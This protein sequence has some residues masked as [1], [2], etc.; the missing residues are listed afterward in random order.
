MQSYLD[1]I[2]DIPDLFFEKN[3]FLKDGT[4]VL[5]DLKKN[6]KR[7]FNIC[8]ENQSHQ[9]FD[10]IRT[11]D[12]YSQII[13]TNKCLDKK[14][15]IH[16]NNYLAFFC[17]KEALS[18]LTNKMIEDYYELLKDPSIKYKKTETS[19]YQMIEEKFPEPDSFKIERCKQWI[20]DNIGLL[21]IEGKYLKIFFKDSLNIYRQENLRYLIPNV[22]LNN[23]YNQEVEKKC[24][25]VPSGNLVLNDKKPFLLHRTRKNELPILMSLEDALTRRKFISLLSSLTLQRK[26]NIFISD[27]QIIACKNGDLPKEI[28]NGFFIKVL[29]GTLENPIVEEDVVQFNPKLKKA[30]EYKNYLQGVEDENYPYGTIICSKEELLQIVD[31]IYFSGQLVNNLFLP[32]EKIISSS[33]KLSYF[34]RSFKGIFENWIYKGIYPQKKV[35]RNKT[36]ELLQYN[37]AQGFTTKATKQMNLMYSIEEIL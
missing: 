35:L 13:N 31:S 16:S 8:K 20:T 33:P 15:I 36:L 24:I 1:K 30:I 21:P 28:I 11:F 34:I 7:I 2:K 14:K 37:I 10:E 19:I 27:S 5:V 25:G 26:Q 18:K 17:K 4:Y 32:D 23:N 6:E 29:P 12:Y 22:F 3:H 9:E